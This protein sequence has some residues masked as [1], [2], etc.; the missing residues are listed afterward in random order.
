MP[1]VLYPLDLTDF[2]D[3]DHNDL[4]AWRDE[5]KGTPEECLDHFYKQMNV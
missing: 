1:P 5:A 2:K 4:I 3:I